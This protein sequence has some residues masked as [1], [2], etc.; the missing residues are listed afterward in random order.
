MKKTSEIEVAEYFCD[1]CGSQLL[2]FEDE[3][4]YVNPDIWKKMADFKNW[5]EIDGKHYCPRCWEFNDYTDEP[6]PKND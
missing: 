2:G 6:Q 4:V 3:K 5:R 1:R